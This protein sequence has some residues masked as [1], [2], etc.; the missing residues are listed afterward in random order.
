VVF[1][2]AGIVEIFDVHRPCFLRCQLGLVLQARALLPDLWPV[3]LL[4]THCLQVVGDRPSVKEYLRLLSSA[5]TLVDASE[6]AQ[7]AKVKPFAVEVGQQL[8]AAK[9]KLSCG[10]RIF[11]QPS[12]CSRRCGLQ[13]AFVVAPCPRHDAG[14]ADACAAP[15]VAADACIMFPRQS[16][17]SFVAQISSSVTSGSCLL[18]SSCQ[19]TQPL[20][21]CC[22]C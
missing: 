20:P 5:L 21:L 18:C 6:A 16:R 7:L 17:P 19:K 4:I 10:L 2:I 8:N 1:C 15:V 22:S 3:L 14:G 13:R 11:L 12:C 9:F